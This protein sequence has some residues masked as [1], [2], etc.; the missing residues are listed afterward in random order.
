MKKLFLSVVIALFALLPT[1]ESK[2]QDYTWGI[3]FRGTYY[4]ALSIKQQL[5]SRNSM[6]YIVSFR[7]HGFQATAIYEWKTPVINNNFH[8]YYGIGGSIGLW[9]DYRDNKYKDELGFRAGVDGILG[10]EFKIP[11]VPITL[12]VDYKP[13]IN[14]IGWGNDFANGAFSVRY[15]F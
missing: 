10:L 5:S 6:D 12:S 9:D 1:K 2:A 11:N 3:G 15:V 7:N 4:P 14:L 13:Y 8:L